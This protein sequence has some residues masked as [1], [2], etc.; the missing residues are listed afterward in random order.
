MRLKA[1]IVLLFV[2]IGVLCLSYHTEAANDYI[3]KSRSSRWLQIPVSDRHKVIAALKEQEAAD[4]Y[5]IVN[6]FFQKLSKKEQEFFNK[7]CWWNYAYSYYSTLLGFSH[8]V[9]VAHLEEYAFK[10]LHT[11]KNDKAYLRILQKAHGDTKHHLIKFV[12]RR[13][14]AGVRDAYARNA[15]NTEDGYALKSKNILSYSGQR[16][17]RVPITFPDITYPD[18]RVLGGILFFVAAIILII[19]FVGAYTCPQ[20]PV[21]RNVRVLFGID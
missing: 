21:F 2:I 5:E 12:V 16:V 20:L 1:C 15:Q 11:T 7:V 14:E 17:Q 8:T 4:E 18:V 13:A 3:Q 10:K 9:E 19:G 6:A